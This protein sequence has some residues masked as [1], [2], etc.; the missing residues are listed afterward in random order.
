[1][2]AAGCGAMLRSAKKGGWKK[3]ARNIQLPRSLA[4]EANLATTVAAGAVGKHGKVM[5]KV[6]EEL[7]FE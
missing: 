1:M 5:E 7:T 2:D 4:L 6:I 3:V